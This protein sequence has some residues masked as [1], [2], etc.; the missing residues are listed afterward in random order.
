MARSV[1]LPG[2]RCN[3][4]CGNLARTVAGL[5]AVAAACSVGCSSS[6]NGVTEVVG[7]GERQRIQW[8]ERRRI[9]WRF[10][11]VAA[12]RWQ[13][14]G[15]RRARAQSGSSAS[16]Q[17]ASV[18]A[19]T[20]GDAAQVDASMALVC[21]PAAPDAGPY[22]VDATGV[23]FTLS[24][25]LLRLEVC[26]DDII[27]VEYTTASSIPMK[28]SLSV[29]ATWPTPSFCMSE[30][31]GTVTITTARMQAKV[32]TATGLVTF[33][34]LAGNTV[35]SEAS[36]KITPATVE[37]VGTNTVQTAWNSPANEALFGLGQHQDG[38]INRKG[39]TLVM[40]QANTEIQIP[41]VVSNKGYGV[42]WD[43]PSITTFAGNAA[44]VPVQLQ[45]RNRRHGRLL[46]LLRTRDRPRDRA[47]PHRDGR[48]AAVPQ[49]E[50]WPL[51][52]EGPLHE[53][54]G[55]HGRRSRL[56]KQQHS[57]RRHRPGLAVLDPLRLGLAAH[58]S[59]PLSR[60]GRDRDTAAYRQHP[61][62]DLDLAPIPDA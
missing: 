3:L 28:T 38:V 1:E 30:T 58:G 37:G 56:S 54:G 32:A 12:E 29:N 42:L 4:R 35:L 40:Q 55:S 45:L 47:L 21:P 26:Q 57:R 44:N 43:N 11:V 50:L 20:S 24:G 25:G 46:L 39:S 48:G 14:A 53:F 59:Q 16:G 13:R 2:M 61:H 31:G 6:T 7:V 27:R 18:D 33:V 15:R 8:P 41:L 23:T 5:V 19:S 22:S 10:R 9:E 60:S 17:M 51:P 34:D 36:K 49:V 62:D 52:V